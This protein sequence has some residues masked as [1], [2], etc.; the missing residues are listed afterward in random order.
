MKV[1]HSLQSQAPDKKLDPKAMVNEKLKAKFGK[2][3]E[4]KSK[5]SSQNKND[6]EV[7]ISEQAKQKH[8]VSKEEFGD[9]KKNAP[10]SEVTQEKLK[11]LLQ[12][13]AFSFNDKERQALQEIL[14]RK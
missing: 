5:E 12:N 10:D 7:V 11:G 3:F 4:P 8:V 14:N 1:D 6:T 2:S 13:G 9:V